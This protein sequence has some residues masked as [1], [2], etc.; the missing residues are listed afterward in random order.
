MVA[1]SRSGSTSAVM[2]LS[3]PS[4]STFSSQVSRSL[5]LAPRTVVLA[6]ARGA[7]C[8]P[9]AAPTVT[10]ISMLHLPLCCL[11]GRPKSSGARSKKPGTSAGLEWLGCDSRSD[12]RHHALEAQEMGER[13]KFATLVVAEAHDQRIAGRLEALDVHLAHVDRG[14]AGG[15]CGRPLGVFHLA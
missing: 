11:D 12:A 10:L 7:C 9:S 13:P 8:P 3:S 6:S 4:A 14:S 5:A 15:A 2:R 1:A